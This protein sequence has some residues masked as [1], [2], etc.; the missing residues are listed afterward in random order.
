MSKSLPSLIV[1]VTQVLSMIAENNGELTPELEA[2]FDGVSKDIAQ[3]AD[4]YAFYMERLDVESEYW[5]QKADSYAKVAKSCKALKER[6][7]ANIKVAMQAM[8]TDE[9]SGEDV[10][11]KL[12]KA[13]PKLV[14]EEERLP[15]SFKMQVVTY[16]PDK[17]RIK[18]E[19]EAG[20]TVDGAK[21][22]EVFTLRKYPARK[23]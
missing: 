19:L 13:A 5:K 21:F 6:L 20:G 14:I 17:D 15:T 16:V 1:E 11:F 9:L 2:F 18:S 12:S 22:E 8:G 4:S 3:K 23:A 10:R 7:N